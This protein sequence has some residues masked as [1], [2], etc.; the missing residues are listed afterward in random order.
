M[1]DYSKIPKDDL[2]TKIDE[3][4]YKLQPESGN[5]APEIDRKNAELRAE[6]DRLLVEWRKRP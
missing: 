1:T 5:N 4:T 3:L 6:S 2:L